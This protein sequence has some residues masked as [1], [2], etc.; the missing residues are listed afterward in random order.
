MLDEDPVRVVR[1]T[2]QLDAAGACLF[3]YLLKAEPDGYSDGLCRACCPLLPANCTSLRTPF[4]GITIP[5]SIYR[6]IG[7]VMIG[8]HRCTRSPNLRRVPSRSSRASAGEP[9]LT[10][11][12]RGWV[13]I[14]IIMPELWCRRVHASRLSTTS[15]AT[16]RLWR[17]SWQSSR[18][19]SLISLWLAE[20]L[21]LVRGPPSHG[22]A[23]QPRQGYTQD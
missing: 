5:I 2:L 9:R 19:S 7:M 1:E 15:T 23:A 4:F 13:N 17:R 3:S 6:V 8:P 20:M 22:G 21:S 18:A 12:L 11:F 10:P 14:D 16:C